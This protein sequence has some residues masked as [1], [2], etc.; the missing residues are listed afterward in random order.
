MTDDLDQ[1]SYRVIIV[2]DDLDQCS[3]KVIISGYRDVLLA[4][5]GQASPVFLQRH[6]SENRRSS[7]VDLRPFPITMFL[8]NFQPMSECSEPFFG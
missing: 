1:C 5:S 4:D 6:S 2:T 8:E 3:Y 7:S